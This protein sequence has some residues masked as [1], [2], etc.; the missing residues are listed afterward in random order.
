MINS[1]LETKVH[2]TLD[3]LSNGETVDIK[4]EWIESATQM[5]KDA[6]IKQ[7]RP[8]AREFKIRMSN[9][10][11]PA[12]QLQME[13]AGEKRSAM[14]YNHIVKMLLG[15]ATEAIMDVILRAAGLN[16]TATKSQVSMKI[17]GVEVKGENDLEIDDRVYD[18]KS[19]SPW[20]FEHKFV[21]WGTL[22]KDD[23][24]GY[25]PQLIGYSVSQGKKPGGWIV[26]NKATGEVKIIEVDPTSSEIKE[27]IKAMEKTVDKLSNDAPFERCFEP[28]V[29]KFRSKPTG[30][31]RLPMTCSFC[32]YLTKCWPEAVYKPQTG[33]KAQSP[34]HFWYAKYEEPSE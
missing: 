6:L 9:V 27:V 13:K 14:P 22:K 8:E 12:C 30:N 28:E 10:G 21:D 24:F 2:M 25:I 16:I 31:L 23:A 29:E 34:R 32:S 4:D 1:M 20:A 19:A 5:F 33:S 3:K 15:D 18:T 11:R 26:V 7:F 17:L